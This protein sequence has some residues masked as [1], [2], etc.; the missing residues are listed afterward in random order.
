VREPDQLPS[1]GYITCDNCGQL[2]VA[3]IAHRDQFSGA[4]LYAVVCTADHLTD[5]YTWE[6]LA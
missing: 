4:Q 2:H 5:W 3:E 1:A 6:R